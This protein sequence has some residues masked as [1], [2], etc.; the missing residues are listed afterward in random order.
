M[1]AWNKD[2][3]YRLPLHTLHFLVKGMHADVMFCTKLWVFTCQRFQWIL[4]S[5]LLSPWWL[6]ADTIEYQQSTRTRSDIGKGCCSQSISQDRGLSPDAV[7]PCSLRHWWL[8]LLWTCERNKLSSCYLGYFAFIIT[9]R[10]IWEY[11][12][13]PKWHHVLYLCTRH[14]GLSLALSL[15]PGYCE[16]VFF[17]I[18]ASKTDTVPS[19]Y[20]L[21][22][23]KIIQS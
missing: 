20:P 1:M 22:T 17:W 11:Y 9:L 2:Y 21:R 15:S 4:H 5:L 16:Y 13:N 18:S 12:S 6:N 3:V 23:W 14:L 19:F 7:R 10:I 8:C